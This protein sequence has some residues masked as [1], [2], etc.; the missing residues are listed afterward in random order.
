MKVK[1]RG[2]SLIVARLF[3]IDAVWLH[4]TREL[5]KQDALT[6]FA[7]A[8]GSP[9][10]GEHD[11]KIKQGQRFAGQMRVGTEIC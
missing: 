2:V 3:E 9:K 8:A 5:F 6:S 1:V 11:A 10:L 4:L 7:P